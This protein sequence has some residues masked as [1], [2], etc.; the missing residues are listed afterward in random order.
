MPHAVCISSPTKENVY[1]PYKKLKLTKIFSPDT[2]IESLPNELL[3]SIF[4]Y[5]CS[6]SEQRSATFVPGAYVSARS[7]EVDELPL[8]PTSPV[9]ATPVAVSHVSR[10]WRALSTALP[11]LWTSVFITETSSSE[12]LYNILVWSR[13]LPL[14]VE[15][16]LPRNSRPEYVLRLWRT[17]LLLAANLGRC[18]S[19][20]VEAIGS[21]FVMLNKAFVNSCAAPWLE[22]L[23][24]VRL[25]KGDPSSFTL[26]DVN[27]YRLTHLHL[28]GVKW[29]SGEQMAFPCLDSVFL[30]NSESRCI[31]NTLKLEHKTFQ[32]FTVSDTFLMP[33]SFDNPVT[34]LHLS[35]AHAESN[36]LPQLDTQSP[37]LSLTL[38]DLS[39]FAW[40]DIVHAFQENPARFNLPRLT[41]LTL[42]NFDTK[43]LILCAKF[44]EA[45]KELRYLDLVEAEVEPF[46]DILKEGPEVWPEL[47]RIR[48]DGREVWA[49]LE[50]DDVN[51]DGWAMD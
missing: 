46:L 28:D 22:S 6:P 19:L 39:A 10:H 1:Y 51:D 43:N 3:A 13:L 24:L 29:S 41:T 12:L 38:S 44:A 31:A 18:K 33:W 11:S 36:L 27:C 14:D 32:T 15:I 26:M 23:R 49:V 30:H 21:Q 7:G 8:T 48:V 17:L 4:H 20:H 50:D 47:R 45:T 16:S 9:I 25:D 2:S 40:G 42:M 34:H 5:V 37:I 35:G